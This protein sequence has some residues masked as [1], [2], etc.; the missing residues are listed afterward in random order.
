MLKRILNFLKQP[1][2]FVVVIVTLYYMTHV[3]EHLEPAII[4]P[5]M[6]NETITLDVPNGSSPVS[7]KGSKVMTC[8]DE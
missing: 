2:V 6:S 8:Y 4:P 1:I 7:H 3:S 5:S